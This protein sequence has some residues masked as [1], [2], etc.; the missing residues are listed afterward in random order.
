M[1]RSRFLSLM[2][3]LLKGRQMIV[4]EYP[5]TMRP[6]YGHGLP[7][8]SMLYSIINRN[9]KEYQEG[10]EFALSLK[11]KLT[12][13]PDHMTNANPQTPTWNNGFLPGLDLVMLYAMVTK[14]KPATYLEIGSG[15]STKVAFRAKKDMQINTQ[16]ISV[17]P[18]PRA[19][20][21]AMV[22]QVIR[23]PFEQLDLKI[24][25]D[26]KPGDIVFVD[27]S[28]R[29]FPNSDAMV[30][31]MEVLPLL[32]PGVMVHLH[33][34][35]LPYDY[36]EFMC[37]RAY[38]EQYGLAAFLLADPVRYH[39]LMP[40]YFIAEDEELN[41]ILVPLWEDPRMPAVERHG[42]SFWI[43]IRDDRR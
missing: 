7:P 2:K 38:S 43:E 31:F 37:N 12:G 11:N 14:C 41:K 23:K 17:D 30:F 24:F 16:L 34:I 28:H 5:V 27:N 22:D 35:Y 42:G 4:L 18:A 9:R 20:I 36:P 8:H 19:E 13:I 33:D 21:D 6:R 15:N 1:A 39:T 40:N 10:L 25:E 26:L 29:I 3:A 32:P